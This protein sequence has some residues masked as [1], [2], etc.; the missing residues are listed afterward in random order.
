VH[1][2]NARIQPQLDS[3]GQLLIEQAEAISG[4]L[5]PRS[6]EEGAA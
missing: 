6:R 4:L 1:G 5:L 2:P 3:V